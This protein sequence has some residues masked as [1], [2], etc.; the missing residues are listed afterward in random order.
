MADVVR[1][2]NRFRAVRRKLGLRQVDVATRARVS[3]ATVSRIERGQI[4][5]MTFQRALRV[6]EALEIG[7]D[8][9]A[10][11]RGGELERL[12]NARHA[13]MHDLALELFETLTGWI[14]ASEVFVYRERGVIDIL[15]WH[16][17]SRTLLIIELKSELVDP[18]ELVGTM[19]KR[20]RLAHEIVRTRGWRPAHVGLWVLLAETRTNRRHVARHRRLLRGAFPANGHAMRAWLREPHRPIAALSFLPLPQDVSASRDLRSPRR[21]RPVA[22]ARSAPRPPDTSFDP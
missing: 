11:W 21:V 14:T 18:Q 7:L 16:E 22:A 2:G 12:V 20:R 4:A 6:A 13:L 10:T 3:V 9:H 17:V 8:L 1:L 19:D 5:S 15:A